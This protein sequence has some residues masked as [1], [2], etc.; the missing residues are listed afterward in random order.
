[1]G[2]GGQVAVVTAE[3]QEAKLR[4]VVELAQEVWGTA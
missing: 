2:A 4:L 1:V 3:G